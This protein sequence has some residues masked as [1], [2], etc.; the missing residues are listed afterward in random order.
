MQPVTPPRRDPAP[1]RWSYRLQR[2]MLTPFIRSILR[3]G[4]PMA[5]AFGIGALYFS[6]QDNRDD[7]RLWLVDIRNEIQTREEFMVRLMAID[8]AGDSVSEDI[9]EIL[10]IDFPVSSFDLDLDAMRLTIAELPA[11]KDV[12]VRIRHG[13]LQVTV[14]ERVPALVWRG[15]DGL[16]LLD[17][18]GFYVGQAGT[19][20]DH[21]NLP[22]IA[23]EGADNA[24]PEA[25]ALIHAAGPLQDRLRGLVR[26]GDRR[27]DLVLDRGQRIL[28][29][30][31]NPVQALERVIA[32]H[33][34]QDVMSR[35]LAMVDM[36]IG[37]RPTIRM[38]TAA[39]EQWWRINEIGF[40]D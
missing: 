14:T 29:P 33:Q 31:S 28:L 6:Y 19:R 12:S 16:S 24:A 5:T 9:R 23:G 13:L 32:V 18:N 21:A 22:L 37:M 34:A 1:S 30:E 7:F 15:R 35:D 25:L 8:G 10:P 20:L 27:W 11:V 4:L 26:M 38:N 40:K 2:L 39:V 17:V 3:V 36:R